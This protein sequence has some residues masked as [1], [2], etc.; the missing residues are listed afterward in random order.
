MMRRCVAELLGTFAIVFFG[1]GTMITLQGT[2][3][4]HLTVNLVFGMVVAAMIYTLGHLSG[5]HF[6]PAVTLG[7]ASIGRF[8]RTEVGGYVIAQ[9]IGAVAASALHSLM[10]TGAPT[11]NFG[12]T[13]PSVNLLTAGILEFVISGFLMLVIVAVATDVR[14]HKA[15]PGLAIGSYVALA[16]LFAGPVSGCSMNPAR[17]LAPALFAAS[18]AMPSLIV[19]IIAPTLGAIGAAHLYDWLRTAR[20][21]DPATAQATV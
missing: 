5:A 20:D 10:L 1:C 12:A 9:V 15:I 6:N 2:V 11:A 14:A 18:A 21:T 3:P 13:I 19:F 17:S 8:P 4:G 7:F 16:G